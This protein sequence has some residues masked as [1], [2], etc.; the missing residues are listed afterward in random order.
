MLIEQVAGRQII[1]ENYD[2]DGK[3][4]G[5]QI[6]QVGQLVKKQDEYNIEV[7]VELYD[8]KLKLTD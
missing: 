7:L 2:K 4:T 6:F 1:R 3:Q 5:K 8:E